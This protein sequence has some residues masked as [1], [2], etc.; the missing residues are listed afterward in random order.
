[1]VKIS[2]L[3]LVIALIATIEYLSGFAVSVVPGWQTEIVPPYM[4]LSVL[5]PIW[6]YL[7]PLGYFILERKKRLPV[8]RTVVIHLIM[9]LF[10][11]LYSNRENLFYDTP[12]RFFRFIVPLALFAIGQV[13]FIIIFV[14]TISRNYE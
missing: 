7:L 11:F 4:I 13:I 10:F 14:R 1:M 8:R 5:L 3:F 6:L 2:L 9:T 12:N